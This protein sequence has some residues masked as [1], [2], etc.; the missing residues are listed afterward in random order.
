MAFGSMEPVRGAALALELM[1]LITVSKIFPVKYQNKS[2]I[3]HFLMCFFG[4]SDLD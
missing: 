1:S 2:E 3:F 4:D